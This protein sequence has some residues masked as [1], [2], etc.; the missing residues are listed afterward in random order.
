MIDE[1]IP[2]EEDIEEPAEAPEDD[3]PIGEAEREAALSG[4][5]DGENGRGRRRRRR[6]R[7]GGERGPAEGVAP[8][9]APQPTDDGLAVVA[10]IGGDLAQPVQEQGAESGWRGEGERGGRRSRRSRGR[11]RY[12]R[13]DAAAETKSSG[14]LPFGEAPAPALTAEAGESQAEFPPLPAEAAAP[15]GEPTAEASPAAEAAPAPEAV[16][17][18]VEPLPVA[19]EPAAPTAPAEVHAP[20]QPKALA[21]AEPAG[22][23]GGGSR[24]SRFRR[25][26]AASPLRLVAARPSDVRRGVTVPPPSFR[27]AERGRRTVPGA[28]GLPCKKTREGAFAPTRVF[29]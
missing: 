3:E 2:A 28:A 7:R 8:S 17:T 13:I 6:R 9:D 22:A 24:R 14:D 27:K 23:G 5:D 21:S 1:P 20:A 4:P 26:A 25:A 29:F 11:H 10:E 16:A 19:A 18:P 12:P 15:A